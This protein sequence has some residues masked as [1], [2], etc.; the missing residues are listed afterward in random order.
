MK[1]KN[2]LLPLCTIIITALVLTGCSNNSGEKIGTNVGDKAPDFSITTIDGQKYE[3]SDFK[4]KIL[5]VT[6]TA[7]WC[8]TCF[9]EAEELAKVYPKFKDKGVEILSVSIDPTDNDELL[10]KFK[11]DYDTPWLYTHPNRAKQ[12]IIDNGLT[13][14]EITYV[15]DQNGVIQYKDS[16]ITLARQI[17]TILEELT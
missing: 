15:I 12:M 17:A 7:S 5:I 3:L 11:K 9:I 10:E 16:G 2:I 1:L 4:G 14:F 13:R 6:S 8:P